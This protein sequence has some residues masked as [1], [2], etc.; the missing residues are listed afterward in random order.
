MLI[1]S[2]KTYSIHKY[3]LWANE[4]WWIILWYPPRCLLHSWPQIVTIWVT[5]ATH[6]RGKMAENKF[7][8]ILTSKPLIPYANLFYGPTGVVQLSNGII[9][10]A[11]YTLDPIYLPYGPPEPLIC[12]QKWSKTVENRFLMILTSMTSYSTHMYVLWANMWCSIILRYYPRCQLDS[13]PHKD[14]LWATI[15]THLWPKIAKN[16]WKILFL[17]MFTSITSYCTHKY[18]LLVNEWCQIILWYHPRCP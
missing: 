1:S 2:I 17:V 5:I 16:C 15:A 9:H 18:V 13:K 3:D 4:C 10:G 12:E 6:K 14:T 7:L 11:Y 8:T